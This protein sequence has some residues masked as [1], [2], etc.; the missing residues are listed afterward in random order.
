MQGILRVIRGN[1]EN[2]WSIR[3]NQAG[4]QVLV[5]GTFLDWWGGGGPSA[6]FLVFCTYSTGSS[7]FV[8]LHCCVNLLRS[9]VYFLSA[10]FHCA[11]R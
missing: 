6:R 10:S 7:C 1:M 5:M 11:D 3:D 2:V 8:L 9:C 4:P